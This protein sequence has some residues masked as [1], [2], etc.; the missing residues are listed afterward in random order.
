MTGKERLLEQRFF[1]KQFTSSL[2]FL[3]KWP[4]G[5][6]TIVASGTKWPGFIPLTWSFPAMR[7]WLNYLT[8]LCLRY[9]KR[10]FWGLTELTYVSYLMPCIEYEFN[11]CLLLTLFQL[12]F[13]VCNWV[14]LEIW[15]PPTTTTKYVHMLI[16]GTCECYHT[17]RKKKKTLQTELRVLKWGDYLGILL[18]NII[19]RVLIRERGRQEGQ[20]EK[21]MWGRRQ[22][23]DWCEC[24]IWR[25]EE[26][27]EPEDT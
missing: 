20:S 21:K 9:I 18:F 11:K 25:T 15:W 3:Q 27:H 23:S 10:L 17:Y 2:T 12:G 6:F 8:S 26:A 4:H 13:I 7:S 1:F 22:R 16:S 14:W 24:W 19:T 5:V